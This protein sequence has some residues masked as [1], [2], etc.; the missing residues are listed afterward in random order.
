MAHAWLRYGRMQF[1]LWR[2]AIFIV[3]FGGGRRSLKLPL[4]P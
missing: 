2:K 1:S 4:F 3:W